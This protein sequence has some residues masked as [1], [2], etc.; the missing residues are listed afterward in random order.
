MRGVF[1]L[2]AFGV[3]LIMLQTWWAPDGSTAPWPVVFAPLLAGMALLVT[4]AALGLMTGSR[5]LRLAVLFGIASFVWFL[6]AIVMPF[7]AMGIYAG[8][9]FAAFAIIWAW[10]AS[11]SKALS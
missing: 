8:F 3:L 1:T 11:G 4:A 2:A 6:V 10:R 7:S 5:D 9:A